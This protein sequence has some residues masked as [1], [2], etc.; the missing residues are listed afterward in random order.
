V[1]TCERD[2]SWLYLNLDQ[3]LLSQS[4]IE[5]RLAHVEHKVQSNLDNISK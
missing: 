3:V 1:R 2:S 5:L 4:L